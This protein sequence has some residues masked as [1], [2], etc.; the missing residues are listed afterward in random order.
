MYKIHTNKNIYFAS[1]GGKHQR[2]NPFFQLLYNTGSQEDIMRSVGRPHQEEDKI[3]WKKERYL[4][5]KGLS[6]LVSF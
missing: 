3:C 1:K 2:I 4:I 5:E 6:H